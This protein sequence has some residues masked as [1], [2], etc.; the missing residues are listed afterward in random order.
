MIS[1]K[2]TYGAS[3]DTHYSKSYDR[4]GKVSS[5]LTIKEVAHG[6]DWQESSVE[7]NA[8]TSHF[9]GDYKWLIQRMLPTFRIIS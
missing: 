2:A 7:K 6:G 8:R 1:L 4:E 9:K 3:T 5:K